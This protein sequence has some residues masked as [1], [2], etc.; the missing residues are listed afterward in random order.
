MH[1][2]FQSGAQIEKM[3][4]TLCLRLEVCSSTRRAGELIVSTCRQR[5]SAGGHAEAS[6]PRLPKVSRK[7]VHAGTTVPLRERARMEWIYIPAGP[8]MSAPEWEARHSQDT[9]RVESNDDY[10]CPKLGNGIALIACGCPTYFTKSVRRPLDARALTTPV[11]E[12]ATIGRARQ[13]EDCCGESAVK[14]K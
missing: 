5:Q 6:F 1:F 3:A 13:S 4:T 9:T 8:A 11:R 7:I 2:Y 12:S 14:A 10:D